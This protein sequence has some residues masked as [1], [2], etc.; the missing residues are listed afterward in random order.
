MDLHRRLISKK[1]CNK[2]EKIVVRRHL[3]MRG[4]EMKPVFDGTPDF[5]VS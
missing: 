3:N 1:I 5:G 4:G 2:T